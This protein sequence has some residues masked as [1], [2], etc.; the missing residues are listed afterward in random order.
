MQPAVDKNDSGQDLV[1]TALGALEIYIE[2]IPRITLFIMQFWV[3]VKSVC[4]SL[5]FRM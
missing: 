5:A 3:I 4:Q 1:I 2:Q